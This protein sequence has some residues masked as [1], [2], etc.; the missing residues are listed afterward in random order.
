MRG[1]PRSTRRVVFGNTHTF[2]PHCDTLLH[3][4]RAG[5]NL[6]QAPTVN[7]HN[8]TQTSESNL[9]GHGWTAIETTVPRG[10]G[11]LARVRPERDERLRF[12]QHL[13]RPAPRLSWELVLHNRGHGSHHEHIAR[14]EAGLRCPRSRNFGT[15]FDV[16]PALRPAFPCFFM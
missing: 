14:V 6:N 11:S 1:I 7:T 3:R 16:R 13:A 8:H 15:S 9:P 5:K 12:G 10:S 2:W 4:G